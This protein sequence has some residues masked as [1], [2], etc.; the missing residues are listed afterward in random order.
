MAEYSARMHPIPPSLRMPARPSL[1]ILRV[2]APVRLSLRPRHPTSSPPFPAYRPSPAP[3]PPPDPFQIPKIFSTSYGEDEASWSPPA[4]A[5]LNVEFLKAGSRG[6]TLL[7]AAGD[8][9][10]PTLSRPQFS[11]GVPPRLPPPPPRHSSHRASRLSASS[12]SAPAPVG[13]FRLAY[14]L[15]SGKRRH[16]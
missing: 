4:A 3:P 2:R 5:R 13:G 15:R 12:L 7:F 16:S 1:P 14:S 6:I 11:S 8:E 9:G 10:A